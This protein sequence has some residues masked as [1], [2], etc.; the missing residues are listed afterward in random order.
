MEAWKFGVRCRALDSDRPLALLTEV[1]SRLRGR[2]EE[3]RIR[4]AEVRQ[5]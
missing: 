2:Q 3:S 4:N 5:E 1:I